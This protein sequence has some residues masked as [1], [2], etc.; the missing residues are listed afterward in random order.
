MAL[1]KKALFINFDKTSNNA[2]AIQKA[3][4]LASQLNLGDRLL[5]LKYAFILCLLFNLKRGYAYKRNIIIPQ[6]KE[7]YRKNK[8]NARPKYQTY[9]IV[10]GVIK[11]L[12]SKG[13]IKFQGHVIKFATSEYYPERSLL[14]YFK[15]Y[16]L[17]D[18]TI[19]PPTKNVILR[20]LREETDDY[21]GAKKYVDIDYNPTQL[22]QKMTRDLFIYNRLR[23]NASIS[24][25]NLP[26]GIFD[27]HIDEF[28]SRWSFNDVEAIRYTKAS[29]VTLEL[30]KSYLVRIFNHDFRRGGRFYRG[31]ESNMPEELRRH[32][33]INGN[34]T[35]ELDYSGH[36]LRM[37]YHLKKINLKTDPYAV[38]PN[39]SSGMRDV[40]KAVS[41]I[42]INAKGNKSALLALYQKFEED[43]NLAK[44]LPDNSHETR[45]RLIDNF[46]AHNKRIAGH[47]FKEKCHQLMNLDSKISNDILMFFEKKGILVLCIH[48]SYI[49]E[50]QHAKKLLKVM[51]EAYRARLGFDPVIK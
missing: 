2:V 31:V 23:E 27:K 18:V 46:K 34:P 4:N 40:Y 19:L 24:L 36:H 29:T 49:I 45:Q 28:L 26:K 38:E 35:V 10:V 20:K 13:F 39:M 41:L 15:G 30:Q 42:G 7:F 6:D 21:D 37:L 32:I 22:T 9:D 17:K 33:H 5:P 11:E 43:E 14:P 16:S 48:D 12:I 51:R 50:K 25:K 8:N 47:L 44:C 1:K 3:K